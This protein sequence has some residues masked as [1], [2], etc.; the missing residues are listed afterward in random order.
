MSVYLDA[1]TA[2]KLAVASV[3]RRADQSDIANE[4]LSRALSS[5]TFYDRTRTPSE[6]LPVDSIDVDSAA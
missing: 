1:E 3:I 6:P 5:V 2:E 4:V